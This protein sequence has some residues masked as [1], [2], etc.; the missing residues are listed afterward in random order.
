MHFKISAYS[1]LLSYILATHL[2]FFMLKL[3]NKR[4]IKETKVS[5]FFTRSELDRKKTG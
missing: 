5:F 1:V 2:F 3:K 4:D